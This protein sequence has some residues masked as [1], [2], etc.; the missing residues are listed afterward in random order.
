VSATGGHDTGRAGEHKLRHAS[1]NAARRNVRR[2]VNLQR[3]TDIQVKIMVNKGDN[4]VDETIV[5]NNDDNSGN[6]NSTRVS[7]CDD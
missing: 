2:A 7:D 1:S 4:G 3:H 5:R 6:M